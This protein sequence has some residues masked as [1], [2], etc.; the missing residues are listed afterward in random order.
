[1]SNIT[2]ADYDELV[3][4]RELGLEFM[5]IDV[6]HPLNIAATIAEYEREQKEDA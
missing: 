2:Q 4:L 6:E 1:M 3:R 5:I